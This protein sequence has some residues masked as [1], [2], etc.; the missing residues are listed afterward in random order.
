MPYIYGKIYPEIDSAGLLNHRFKVLVEPREDSEKFLPFL[1]EACTLRAYLNNITDSSAYLELSIELTP[2]LKNLDIYKRLE[3]SLIEPD[4]GIVD[5][6]EK[7]Q[8]MAKTINADLIITE[9]K[10]IIDFFRKEKREL[11][12]L[13][14][15]YDGAKRNMEAFVRGH[16]IP[17]SFSSPTWNM[18]WSSFYSMSD[19][20][21]KKAYEIYGTKLRKVRLDEQ[22]IEI[23]RSLLLNRVSNICYTKDKLL[24]YIQQR[25]Y[26]KRQGW[27]RQGF[28]FEAA[29]YLCHYYLLL[30]G[31]VDQL[32]RI[33]NKAL[34]LNFTRFTEINIIRKDF[35]D[36]IIAIDEGLGN[37]YRDKDFLKWITLLKKKR[38]FTAHEG[39]IIL[40]PLMEKPKTEPSEEEL[41]R[42]AQAT[43]EW[44]MMK[45]TLPPELF[46]W[47]HT[48][49]KQSIRISKFKVLLDDTMV[50]QDGKE[51]IIFRP[52]ISIDWDFDNFERMI[53]NTLQVLHE[54]L[55]KKQKMD[56]R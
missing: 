50:I 2:N 34:G 39:S 18:P 21:C 6:Y 22:T 55:E 49:L 14:E 52:L 48:S 15:D 11:N 13:I 29:Y 56:K 27:K 32:S 10:E 35:V 9:N 25:N 8:S 5:G 45:K 1:I 4:K 7:F 16:E 33:L 20:F 42:E 51:Q 3:L 38:H 44:T 53:L 41:E 24:F 46:N 54:L 19:N 28:Q 31:G 40:S 37:I 12:F 23:A 30:W 17:W 36:K 47:Y 26:A 43:S